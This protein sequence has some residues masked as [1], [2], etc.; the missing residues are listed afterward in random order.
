[1][2]THKRIGWP[3]LTQ[4]T[5]NVS[6]LASRRNK[7]MSLIGRFFPSGNQ[8]I[9]AVQYKGM[10]MYRVCKPIHHSAEFFTYYGDDYAKSLG[11][12]V[13]KFK[14]GSAHKE[15]WHL[16]PDGLQECDKCDLAFSSLAAFNSH[17]C[18][19]K[20]TR[21]KVRMFRFPC[22][23]HPCFFFIWFSS[24]SSGWVFSSGIS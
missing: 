11:I 2:W 1:M 4:Q 24:L 9:I 23:F 10:I 20:A 3:W 6:L 19:M 13:D 12:D 14:A 5:T 8:N 17:A 18:V 7:K 15:Y 21:P 16:L 22:K